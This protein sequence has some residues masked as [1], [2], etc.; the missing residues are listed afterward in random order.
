MEYSTLSNGIQIPMIGYGVI[1]IEANKTKDC[2]LKA[3]NKGYRL[4]DT[5]QAYCNEAEVGAAITE[6]NVPR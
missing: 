2:V 6:T 4:I 5:A 1:Q 3:I